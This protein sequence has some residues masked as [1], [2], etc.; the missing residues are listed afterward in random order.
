MLNKCLTH[1]SEPKLP[2]M[3]TQGLFYLLQHLFRTWADKLSK[4]SRKKNWK[5][6]HDFWKL[7]SCHYTY[8]WDCR[9]SRKDKAK[10]TSEPR[11]TDRE[12]FVLPQL[13]TPKSERWLNLPEA[14]RKLIELFLPGWFLCYEHQT[15]FCFVC[16][17]VIKNL[18]CI[19]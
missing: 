4:V 14:L 19:L 9:R 8:K 2:W 1:S 11:K 3:C 18:Q 5:E 16:N 17:I 13:K 6:F 7:Q 10:H 15:F 12:S